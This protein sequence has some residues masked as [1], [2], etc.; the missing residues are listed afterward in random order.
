MKTCV[1]CGKE[2]KPRTNAK[3]CGPECS[4]TR[5]QSLAKKSRKK[6]EWTPD[7]KAARRRYQQSPR[8]KAKQKEYQK[9]RSQTQEYREY[10]RAYQKGEKY[11]AKQKE[12]QQ[13]EK[14][15]GYRLWLSQQPHFK[16]WRRENTAK[17]RAIRVSTELLGKIASL[18]ERCGNV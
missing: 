8:Y 18:N 7:R 14:Y 13:S 10:Q 6:Y 17:N 4:Q 1:V 3:T 16:D 12:Y 5:S 9:R 2:F 11:K 15:I